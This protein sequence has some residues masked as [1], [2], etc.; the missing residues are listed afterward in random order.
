MKAAFWKDVEIAKSDKTFTIE[1][2]IYFPPESV[3]MSFLKSSDTHTECP[4]KGTASYYNVI[5]GENVNKDAAWYYPY[6]KKDSIE[7]AGSMNGL[8]KADFANYIAFWRGIEIKEL[9]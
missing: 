5:V 9:S 1:G 6:P 4:W 2:N 3:N 8:P 7:I